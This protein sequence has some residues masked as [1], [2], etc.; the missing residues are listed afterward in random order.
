MKN[1]I[2]LISLISS[3]F[4][5]SCTAMKQVNVVSHSKNSIWKNGKRISIKSV[6]G[7]TVES[8]FDGRLFLKNT[9]GDLSFYVTITNNTDQ[10]LLI[11]PSTIFMIGYFNKKNVD[12]LG[13]STYSLKKF[14]LFAKNPELVIRIIEN[15]INRENN[16]HA[17]ESACLLSGSLLS[18]ASDESNDYHSD[19]QHSKM[20][21]DQKLRGLTESRNFWKNQT[22]RKTSLLPN[23]SI[24]GFIVFRFDRTLTTFKLFFPFTNP[25]I[26]FAYS[27]Q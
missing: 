20:E 18:L 5:T 2:I 11:D 19:I 14:K 24:N 16:S 7:L 27:I 1:L 23:T 10:T 22:L 26:T 12:D 4:F 13:E 21:H 25:S 8:N 3:C 9:S 17:V 6:D 15:S